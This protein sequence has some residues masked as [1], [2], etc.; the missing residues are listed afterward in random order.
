MKAGLVL[1]TEEDKVIELMC[2][3]LELTEESEVIVKAAV[4]EKGVKVFFETVD[5]LVI[6]DNEKERVKALKVVI[7]TKEEEI[8]RME[9]ADDNGS[10]N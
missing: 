1:K 7:E 5:E 9:G 10:S 4:K 3:L 2:V 8:E 6:D